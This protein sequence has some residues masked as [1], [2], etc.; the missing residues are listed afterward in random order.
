[1]MKLLLLVPRLFLFCWKDICW[2]LRVQYGAVSISTV[3]AP[4]NCSRHLNFLI[5]FLTLIRS[6]PEDWTVL[7]R[8]IPNY[9]SHFLYILSFIPC[10]Y[11]FSGDFKILYFSDEGIPGIL[12]TGQ[13][14]FY[15]LSKMGD[16]YILSSTQS[17]DYELNQRS[18]T[19]QI[20]DDSNENPTVLFQIINIDDEPPT[21]TSPQ[22]SFLV[23]I[24]FWT[25]S[26]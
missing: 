21:L 7:H 23:S 16:A 22:C 8:M 17:F 15:D 25:Y 11:I 2:C 5:R 14:F 26:F 9:L 13:M 18:Y 10:F 4:W 19:F 6:N 20:H 1:M 12:T 3:V 24:Y